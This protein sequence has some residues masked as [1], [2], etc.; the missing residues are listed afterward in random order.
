MSLLEILARSC[1]QIAAQLFQLDDGFHKHSVYEAWRDATID[2]Q[3][4]PWR[5]PSL[6]SA[7]CHGSYIFH[8]QYPHGI[9]DVVG[10][11]AEARIFGGV[12]VFD[13]GLSGAEVSTVT[14]PVQ[15][16]GP[17]APESRDLLIGSHGFLSALSAKRNVSTCGPPAVPVDTISSHARPV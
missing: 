8:E 11:W 5:V 14:P 3:F 12:V 6:P 16:L 15:A 17:Q 9:A 10:Y 2:P 13:R 4:N 1:H 7:F